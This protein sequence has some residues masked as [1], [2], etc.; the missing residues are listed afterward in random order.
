[1]TAINQSWHKDHP[2]TLNYYT[3]LM[4]DLKKVSLQTETCPEIDIQI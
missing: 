4:Y 1:M 3:H 2:I